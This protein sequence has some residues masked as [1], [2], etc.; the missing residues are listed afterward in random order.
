MKRIHFV[1]LSRSDYA[2]V[3]PVALA[4]ERGSYFDVKLIA[5]GSHLLERFGKTIEGIQEDGFSSLEV[6]D[7]LREEDDSDADIA[8]SYARAVEVFVKIFSADPPD[9]VFILGDRWEMMAV[10]SAASM[11]RIPIAHHSGGDITQGSSDNQTRY[12]LSELAHLHFT[13]LEDHRL[14]LIKRG[15][16]E[17]RVTVTGEPALT[18]LK[19]IAQDAPDVRSAL[20]L[21][22]D[23][24]FV[25]A[26]FHPT[27][28]DSSAP[29]EQIAGFIKVLDLIE[30]TIVLTAPN[31][32]PGSGSFFE[33][34]RSYANAHPRVHLFESLGKNYYAAMAAAKFMI[35]NSSSGLW[36]APSFGLPVVNIGPRQDGRERG[37]NV[38]DAP[39]DID[40]IGKAIAKASDPAFR[41]SLQGGT[42]PYVMDNTIERILSVLKQDKPKAE[43]LAKKLVDPLK[44]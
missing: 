1:T 18:E 31:P 6:A 20:G 38:I 36:E 5:G 9:C 44:V 28:Y 34:L 8:A 43:L 35:G 19:N 2:S 24:D 11:L 10:A 7:F 4:A 17:W 30:N 22:G 41:K 26:T 23:E 29:E 33:V 32:D 39:L 25:L 40:E 27:S 15:E 37:G 16:E 42:N 13:A 14:R 12:V 3:R 21:G